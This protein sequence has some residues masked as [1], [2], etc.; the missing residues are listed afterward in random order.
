MVKEDIKDQ[1]KLMDFFIEKAKKA[2]EAGN[3]LP[4]SEY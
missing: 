3:Y 2:K 1:K 4:F